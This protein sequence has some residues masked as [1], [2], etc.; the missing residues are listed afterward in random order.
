M[1]VTEW[2]F[3]RGLDVSYGVHERR[4]GGINVVIEGTLWL[5]TLP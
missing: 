2:V 4:T 1:V 3:G 5:R